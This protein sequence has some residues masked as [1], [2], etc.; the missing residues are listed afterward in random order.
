MATVS[1]AADRLSRVAWIAV[2]LVVSL[3]AVTGCSHAKDDAKGA[4]GGPSQSP[5]VTIS[6]S[7]TA[8]ATP[9]LT[10][11][12]P[13]PQSSVPTLP[14]YPS[15]YPGA[16]MTAWGGNDASYLTLLTNPSV[17]HQLLHDLADT[18]KHWTHITDEGAMGS[19]YAT[20]YNQDGDEITL[21]M[22]NDQLSQHHWHAGSV[23]SW[24]PMTYPNDETAYV[25]AFMNA[26]VNGNRTRMELLGGQQVAAHFLAMS[27]PDSSFT[28]AVVPGSGAAGHIMERIRDTANGL[29]ARLIIATHVVEAARAHGIEDCDPTC[30]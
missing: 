25:K 19:G 24:D 21:R 29:D 15:D 14:A 7:V 23:Q 4:L 11:T 17:A 12:T 6:P 3:L 18:D 30:S 22:V 10:P 26:W 13:A 20:Y 2:T 27:A 8:P 5:S 9:T 16:I 28:V 1:A